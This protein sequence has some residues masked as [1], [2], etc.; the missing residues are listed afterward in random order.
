MVETLPWKFDELADELIIHFD[1]N[2]H[3]LSL[4]TFI[5]TAD[6]ARRVVEALDRTFFQ[7]ELALDIMVLPPDEGS[8]VTRLAIV[9]GSTGVFLSGSALI[10]EK[11]ISLVESDV[12]A[13]YV[14]GLTGKAPE[15]WARDLGKT[16][17]VVLDEK[18]ALPAREGQDAE[19]A[20][21]DADTPEDLGIDT[22]RSEACR[23]ILQLV[24]SMA[25]GILEASNEALQKIGMNTGDLPDASDARAEFF[26]ACYRDPEVK[27]VGFSPVD[28][29]P[30]PRHSFPERAQ[31]PARK[32]TDDE[33]EWVV[34]QEP[35]RVDSPTWDQDRQ[36]SRQWLAVD[37]RKRSRYFVIEDAEF[38]QRLRNKQLRFEGS[39][40]LT[41]QWAYQIVGGKAKNRRVLRVLEFNGDKLADPLRPDA[42]NAILGSYSTVEASRNGPSLLDFM[43][44]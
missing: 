1:V 41:V 28:D 9:L 11:A 25:R 17:R 3:H 33:P 2:D 22:E 37:E 42:I 31:K 39:D 29:F 44:E 24:S 30:I 43:D 16:H 26:E 36:R 13:A 10:I 21:L 18:S 40:R 7:G 23:P 12:G 6:S 5:V 34:S 35:I 15:D 27:R 14:E 4:D 19:T 32:K 20:P 38:W 8:F